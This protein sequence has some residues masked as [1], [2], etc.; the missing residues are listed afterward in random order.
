MKSWSV[1]DPTTI[2]RGDFKTP[3]TAPEPSCLLSLSHSLLCLSIRAQD[4]SLQ[5]AHRPRCVDGRSGDAWR[6]H[7]SRKTARVRLHNKS[8]GAP[9]R[10]KKRGGWEECWRQPGDSFQVTSPWMLRNTLALTFFNSTSRFRA[11]CRHGHRGTMPPPPKCHDP[12]PK[13]KLTNK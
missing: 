13:V 12:P 5:R 3:S 7:D 11:G 2:K 6:A 9:A 4:S 1:Y 10:A 8:L